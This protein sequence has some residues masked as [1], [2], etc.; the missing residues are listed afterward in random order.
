MSKFIEK[1][2]F[3]KE[4]SKLNYKDGEPLKLNSEF[5]FFHNK[6]KF[7]KELNQLQYLLKKY[8]GNSLIASGIRDS[9]LKEDYSNKYL[10]VLFTTN[11]TIKKANDI[12]EKHIDLN[13]TNG[14]FYLESN[15]QYILLLTRDMEGLKLGINIFEEILSQTFE[16][17]IKQ[18][19][20]DDFVKIRPLEIFNCT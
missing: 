13:L 10:I 17:Y 3:S 5:N 14:C 18:K 4:L 7:R 12:I 11:E 15:S 19:A 20:F 6:N 9:Y 16:D 8:T 1:Y 2:E